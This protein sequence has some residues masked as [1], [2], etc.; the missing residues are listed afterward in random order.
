MTSDTN[1]ESH[2][3]QFPRAGKECRRRPL[4]KLNSIHQSLGK[5]VIEILLYQKQQAQLH[6]TRFCSDSL[7][8]TRRCLHRTYL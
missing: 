7:H 8:A 3:R 5:N 4:I 1:Y 6:N 2:K